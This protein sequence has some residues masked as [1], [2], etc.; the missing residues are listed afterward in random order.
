MNLKRNLNDEIQNYGI[1]DV[2]AF[3]RI[4][5]KWQVKMKLGLILLR[6]S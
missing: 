4:I 2:E 6:I 3:M 1:D 5:S